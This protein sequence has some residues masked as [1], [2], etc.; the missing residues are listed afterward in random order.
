[1]PE[2]NQKR[3]QKYVYFILLLAAGIL[4]FYHLDEIPFFNDELSALNRLG[5]S[6]F[7]ELVEKGI[8]PDG[9]PAFTQTF[10]FFWT[11]LFGTQEALVRLPFILSGMAAIV[12]FYQLQLRLFGRNAA[13]FFLAIAG[14]GQLFIFDSV[15]ARPYAFGML[16]TAM[17]A[18]AQ[19]QFT[20]KEKAGVN[21]VILLGLTLSLSAYTHYFAALTSALIYLI[22]FI[23]VGK[24]NRLKY[25]SA[26]VL[27]AFMYLPHIS[28][29][30]TQIAHGGIGGPEGWLAEPGLF[31]LMEFILAGVGY[32]LIIFA[33]V[34]AFLI[35]AIIKIR[36]IHFYQFLLVPLFVFFIGYFYSV[37]QNPV[38]HVQTFVFALPF[39]FMAA[40]SAIPRGN[41]SVPTLIPLGV[42]AVLIWS[43]IY[44][45]N[46]Y[47]TMEA[48]P[49]AWAGNKTADNP[50]AVGNFR[51]NADYIRFYNQAY[52]PPLD[53]V[54]ALMD[55]S[56]DGYLSD[57]SDYTSDILAGKRFPHVKERI[58]GFTFTGYHLT[59][60]ED[61]REAFGSYF[62]KDSSLSDTNDEFISLREFDLGEDEW[63]FAHE[64]ISSVEFDSL[65]P[66]DLHLVFDLQVEGEPKHWTAA[67]FA[68]QGANTEDQYILAHGLLLWNVFEWKREMNGAGLKIYL[69]NPSK[70]KL[71]ISHREVY[72][73]D[74]N[75]NRYGLLSN[76]P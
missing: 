18:Y 39:L 16:F 6:G 61:N 51:F 8:K 11:K 57:G 60:G 1:M 71:R 23:S 56:S 43:L 26:G 55:P 37:F 76:R 62:L 64:I 27:G 44:E 33:A 17:T 12:I 5:F 35:Y 15:M 58:N 52:S 3:N 40:T 14:S 22:G 46:H 28:I 38:M 36:N 24:N 19:W 9:H 59:K 70:G 53:P 29:F 4:R 75:P 21:K 7:A 13:N 50:N 32:N 20:K 72:R 42:G 31:D 74:E 49:F 2:S 47:Q 45:R 63:S 48:Q 66:P 73:R 41:R 54:K 69:W 34:S 10:L 65:P 67:K 30:L 68:D 25:L